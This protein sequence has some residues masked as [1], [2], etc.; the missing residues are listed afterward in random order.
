MKRLFTLF[1]AV[2]MIA[3]AFVVPSSVIASDDIKIVI[4]GVEQHYDVMPVIIN[5]RTLVPMRGIYEALG[6]EI[7]WIDATKTVVGARDNKHIK[8]RI[9]SD[10]YYV[11]GVEQEKKLDVPAQ[12]IN[13]RTMVPVRFIAESFGET[14]NWNGDTRTVEITSDYLKEVAVSDKLAHLDSRF[15]R[16]IPREFSKSNELGDWIFLEG[17]SDTVTNN[18]DLSLYGAA[19]EIM[20]ND[21]FLDRASLSED[22]KSTENSFGKFEIFDIND[23]KINSKRAMRAVTTTVPPAKNQHVL[24]YGDFLKD[25]FKAGDNVLLTFKARLTEGGD[26]SGRGAASTGTIWTYLQE[27]VKYAKT[28]WQQFF[29]T[30]KWQTM[31][32]PAVMKDDHTDFGIRLGYCP[33]PQTVEITDFKILNYGQELP[34]D[35]MLPSYFGS[36]TQELEPDAPWRKEAEK[37]IEQIRKGDFKIKVTDASGNPIPNAKVTFDMYE[38]EL[39][40]GSVYQIGLAKKDEYKEAF[41]KY[42]NGTVM[43]S[44][45]KW[46]TFENDNNDKARTYM[47]EAKKLGAL[48]LRDHAILYDRHMHSSTQRLIP[49][50]VVMAIKEGK[51]DYVD[52]RTKGWIYRISDLFAGEF[53]EID[54]TNEISVAYKTDRVYKDSA[55]NDVMCYGVSY[56]NTIGPEYYDKIFKWTREVNPDAKLCFTDT[57]TLIDPA[58][59]K[60]EINP[61]LTNLKK[62]EN[63]FDAIGIHGHGSTAYI[64]PTAN[65]GMYNEFYDNYGAVSMLTEFG[66][67]SGDEIYDANYTR[68]LF[69]AALANEHF[70]GIYLWGFKTYS[71]SSEGITDKCFMDYDGRIKPCGEMMI[72]IIYNKMYTHNATVTTD[73]N[74][75]ATI[76]GFYGNYDVTVDAKGKNK[77]LMAAFHKGYENLLEVNIDDTM[78]AAI[79]GE[80]TV[81]EDEVD[82][83]NTEVFV[84]A[85]TPEIKEEPKPDTKEEKPSTSDDNAS[86]GEKVILSAENITSKVTSK[87]TYL[88]LDGDVIKV[89]IDEIPSSQMTRCIQFSND[90]I[91]G[92]ISQGDV[93]AFVFKVRLVSGGENGKGSMIPYV[94]T[95]KDAG[96]KKPTF[97]TADFSTEWVT[98]TVPF[99]GIDDL[100]GGGIR[101]GGLVQEL[102]FKDFQLINYGK[103]VSIE[104]LPSTVR[105]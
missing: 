86:Q 21:E 47:T 89:K 77:K 102:E 67:N 13:S 87:S 53:H 1:L 91:K 95:S 97:V 49:D 6:A 90:D 62:N 5:G 57:T 88:K 17:D 58:K 75:E 36:G 69:I 96:Y 59:R 16:P 24:Y 46:G 93:C 42:F 19:T 7:T 83:T 68:D 104:S 44:N 60:Q 94:Q 85:T 63:S 26:S 48:Y 99:V 105:K 65:D 55:G 92:K 98:C 74:G 33:A 103:S 81:K 15:H 2:L 56:Y 9:N 54:V 35:F 38:S 30:D 51:M 45:M 3:S 28:I 66:M 4:N 8:L 52:E 72:D 80:K 40:F 29:I 23:E 41:S 70:E 73:A 78:Y 39:P 100:V 25:R 50:D 31:Y 61:I 14:V 76:R 27:K 43:E 12:I 71:A 20:S 11:D 79:K 18:D 32:V 82:N 37:R 84:P 10:S 64:A 34:R 22:K 101:L